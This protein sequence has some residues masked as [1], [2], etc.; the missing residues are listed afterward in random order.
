VILTSESAWAHGIIGNSPKKVPL[1]GKNIG[2]SL[3]NSGKNPKISENT[4]LVG[5]LE[6]V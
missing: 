4:H 5:G 2:K 1:A 3:G 6:H